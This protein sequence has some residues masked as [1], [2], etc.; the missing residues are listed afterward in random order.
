MGGDE[1]PV[2]AEYVQRRYNGVPPQYVRFTC[3]FCHQPLIAAGM[4]RGAKKKPH[5]K[6]GRNNP[7][8]QECEAYAATFGYDP[9][10]QRIPLPLFI[11]RATAERDRFIVDLGLKSVGDMLGRLERDG[12]V[13]RAGRRCYSVNAERF[14][15]GMFRLPLDELSLGVSANVRLTGTSLKLA[16][17]WGPIEDAKLA[18]IFTRDSESGEGRRIAKGGH[19]SFGDSIYILVPQE[20]KPKVTYAFPSSR[21]VGAAGSRNSRSALYVYTVQIPNKSEMPVKAIDFLKECGVGVSEAAATPVALWPPCLTTSGSLKPVF[22]ESKFILAFSSSAPSSAGVSI[23]ASGDLARGVELSV[24]N[25]RASAMGYAYIAPRKD[26]RF[27]TIN[28]RSPS[29]PVILEPMG[30]IGAPD[31]PADYLLE[32]GTDGERATF[33]PLVPGRIE[34]LCHLA[35]PKVEE[36]T[37]RC[38]IKIPA[39][40]IMRF[41]T[42]LSGGCEW[43]VVYEERAGETSARPLDEELPTASIRAHICS[44][45]TPTDFGF[46]Q[47]RAASTIPRETVFM[48]D[49]R[50][51]TIRRAVK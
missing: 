44:Y 11:R 40:G 29:M 4:R 3:P 6:H 25:V 20:F 32:D 9:V 35:A 36:I 45:Y 10:P 12:A 41:L 13:L 47:S 51:A 31:I 37:G 30:T 23:H 50:L 1:T 38:S 21:L 22:S 8:A 14:G 19:A 46:A 7:K 26:V 42:S 16:D 43:L 24:K 18:L 34:F 5:F 2:S 39:K 28:G 27:L 17:V 48:A 15:H 49:K 33:H